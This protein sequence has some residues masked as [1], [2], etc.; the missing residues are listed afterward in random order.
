MKGTKL[1]RGSSDNDTDFI[2]NHKEVLADVT[3]AGG[4]V[5]KPANDEIFLDIDTEE[6]YLEFRSR[7]LRIKKWVKDEKIY[8][9]KSGLPHRHIVIRMSFPVNNWQRIAIQLALNSDPT[10]EFLSLKR[11]LLEIPD[12][13]VLFRYPEKRVVNEEDFRW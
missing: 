1:S 9:S 10:K 12:P 2:L 13:V 7:L 8:Q 11:I 4:E 5:I 3:C 6:D